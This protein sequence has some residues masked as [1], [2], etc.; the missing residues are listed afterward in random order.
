MHLWGSESVKHHSLALNAK[1][2][3]NA[4]L[5]LGIDLFVSV[6]RNNLFQT[7]FEHSPNTLLIFCLEDSPVRCN[8]RERFNIVKIMFYPGYRDVEELI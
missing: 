8:Q 7:R 4:D 3:P 1:P 5:T 2:T 6:V